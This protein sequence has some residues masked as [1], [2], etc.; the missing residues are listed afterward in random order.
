MED[1]PASAI[2]GGF[3]EQAAG[4]SGCE[5]AGNLLVLLAKRS[6]FV[7]RF[8]GLRR[9]VVNMGGEKRGGFT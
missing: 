9:R 6:Y 1:Q 5:F 4:L 8:A 2:L 7:K 3:S